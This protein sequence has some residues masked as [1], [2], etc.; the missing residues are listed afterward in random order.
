MY[1][2]MAKTQEGSVFQHEVPASTFEAST[3]AR[4]FF[5]QKR[6]FRWD[7]SQCYTPDSPYYAVT[8]HGLDVM[9]R[10]VLSEMTLLAKD[11]DVDA[12]YNGT[13][14]TTMYRVG[15]R[16][17]YEGLHTSASLFQSVM[18][19]RYHSIKML[20]II[21]LI[22]TILLVLSYTTLVLR[23]YLASVAR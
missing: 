23:P 11:D 20:H 14:Y 7:Q 15:V 12:V 9:L 13:R 2:G 16:D 1:G 5:R 18:L 10:R 17:L 19:D 22:I 21:M 4:D 3:I 6:C 8:H